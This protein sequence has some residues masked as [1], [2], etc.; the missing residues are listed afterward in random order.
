MVCTDSKYW[1][2]YGL[3]GSG[4]V[5]LGRVGCGEVRCGRVRCGRVPVKT[6]K[7]K[8]ENWTIMNTSAV[9]PGQT[10]EKRRWSET[11][12]VA[13]SAMKE[14]RKYRWMFTIVIIRSIGMRIAWTILQPFVGTATTLSLQKS[15]NGDTMARK[16][17]LSLMS[18]NPLRGVL[19][20]RKS[21]IKLLHTNQLKPEWKE[22]RKRRN[23]NQIRQPSARCHWSRENLPL[24]GFDFP[25]FLL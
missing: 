5:G 11:V 22:K 25:I 8:P 17:R 2:L 3:V 12:S 7:K 15:E 10:S 23:R 24:T 19:R 20:K 18:P 4:R 1:F 13:D 16:S 6:T 21:P 9:S 14:D